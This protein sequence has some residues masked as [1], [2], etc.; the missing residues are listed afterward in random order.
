MASC[1]SIVL[2]LIH[3]NYNFPTRKYKFPKRNLT[4]NKITYQS[5][6]TNLAF[7]FIHLKPIKRCSLVK[8]TRAGLDGGGHTSPSLL[9][10][11]DSVPPP[12]SVP[13]RQYFH[14]H[15]LICYLDF[16]YLI[17]SQSQ[18]ETSLGHVFHGLQIFRY[19]C[20][21]I[22]SLIF[23]LAVWGKMHPRK[24]QRTIISSFF[25]QTQF[26]CYDLT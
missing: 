11:G 2:K 5:L 25:P 8:Q 26:P 19:S 1:F 6:L 4:T 9:E 10:T 7:I 17:F 23:Y 15:S 20:G 22:H 13:H 16:S 24:K 21:F 12:S 3:C 18:D 14:Q